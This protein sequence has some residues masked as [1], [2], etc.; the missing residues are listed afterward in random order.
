MLLPN[1]R[2]CSQ[3]RPVA[4]YACQTQ[5]A[6]SQALQLA[7]SADRWYLLAIIRCHKEVCWHVGG[8]VDLPS[9]S[10]SVAHGLP[11]APWPSDEHALYASGPSSPLQTNSSMLARGRLMTRSSCLD[12]QTG[13][14]RALLSAS[15]CMLQ[16]MT[17]DMVQH[18]GQL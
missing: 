2:N 17:V 12:R 15:V 3:D 4:M 5:K 7:G 18:F 16:P 10:K 6:S 1:E 13:C 14:A 8:I 11:A 9:C